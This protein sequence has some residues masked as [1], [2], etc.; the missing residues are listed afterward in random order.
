MIGRHV[1]GFEVVPVGLDV[2]TL[3]DLE[4]ESDEHILET[5]PCLRDHVGVTTARPR[6][7]LGEV[8]PFG[9][10]L[11]RPLRCGELASA[12]RQPRS[13]SGRGLVD[14]LAGG[15]LLLDRRQPGETGS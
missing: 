13:N 1:E 2:W 8:E 9:R 12:I 10:Q 3:G 4:A 5:L 6:H 11:S 15:L 14:R 7:D